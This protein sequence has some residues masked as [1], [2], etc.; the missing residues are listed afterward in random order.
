M[1]EEKEREKSQVIEDEAPEKDEKEA[2]EQQPQDAETGEPAAEGGEADEA[3]KLSAEL[4]TLKATIEKM[5]K[6]YLLL[7][8]EFDNFRKRTLR[9]KA[10]LIKNGNENCMKAIL[11]V[12][13]D[14]ER[15]LAAVEESNDLNGVKEGMNLIYNKFKS[16]LEQNGVKEIPTKDAD[17][18]TEYHEAVTT[19][20]APD[21][22]QKGKVIDTVQKGY[23]LNDKVIRFAKVVVGE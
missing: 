19:F 13:D 8:A 17:F 22:A 15:G 18:D 9:E 7:M 10:D 4:D 20:P 2:C 11:P 5:Q 3:A 14:F 6:D 16:F 23:T 21:P 12:I 1:A